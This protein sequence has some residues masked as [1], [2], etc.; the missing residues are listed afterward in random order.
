ML[1]LEP[2]QFMSC[3]CGQYFGEPIN[4]HLNRAHAVTYYQLA[5]DTPL[6]GVSPQIYTTALFVAGQDGR[7]RAGLRTKQILVSRTAT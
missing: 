3:T 6:F 4:S 7:L 2:R 1:M 5:E